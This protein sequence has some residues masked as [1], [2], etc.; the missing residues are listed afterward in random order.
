MDM[1]PDTKRALMAGCFAI[2]GTLIPI[3]TSWTKDRDTATQR[4][5]QLDEATKRV[6]FWD[7]WLKL[8][9]TIGDAEGAAARQR[10]Q[11]EL[12]MLCQLLAGASAQLHIE[13]AVVQ[14]RTTIFETKLKGLSLPR[15][16]L[17]LYAPARGIAWL[18]RIFYFFFLVLAIVDPLLTEDGSSAQDTA[19]GVFGFLVIASVFG[20][21][22][23]LIERPRKE[24]SEVPAAS[25][26][27]PPDAGDLAT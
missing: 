16:L 1:N 12:D 8:S 3:I 22:S 17:L 13:Q 6:Q 4:S 27:S 19:F 25:P 18:P 26:P 7:Q 9:T 20:F 10:V 2:A 23:H 5:K 11:H 15:R 24:A 21:L 14:N